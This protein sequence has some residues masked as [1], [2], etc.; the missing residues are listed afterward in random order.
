MTD[1]IDLIVDLIIIMM[2]ILKIVVFIIYPFV[3]AHTLYLPMIRQIIILITSLFMMYQLPKALG[4]PQDDRR[5]WRV[6]V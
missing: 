4:A 2:L 1:W 3:C 5:S 6:M